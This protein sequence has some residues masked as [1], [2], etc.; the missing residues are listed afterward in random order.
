MNKQIPIIALAVIFLFT[1]TAT[2]AVYANPLLVIAIP[3]AAILAGVGILATEV[4]ENNLDEKIADAYQI[5]DTGEGQI[6]AKS[7]DKINL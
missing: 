7:D 5:N 1:F 2:P 3:L 4:H 6:I